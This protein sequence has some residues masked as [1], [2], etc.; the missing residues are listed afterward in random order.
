MKCL[1]R[2]LPG[3]ISRKLHCCSFC[4]YTTHHSTHIKNH[5]AIHLGH[6]PYKCQMCSKAFIQ[7]VHLHRHLL[8]H[9][10]I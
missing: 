4:D 10:G 3:K 8:T 7:K 5:E 6:K 1:R 2:E 9:M